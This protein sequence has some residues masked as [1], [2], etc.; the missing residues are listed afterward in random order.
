MDR[1]ETM[2]GELVDPVHRH[3]NTDHHDIVF[4]SIHAAH[5]ECSDTEARV[6]QS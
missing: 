5:S 2:T 6:G 4:C 1:H 3:T